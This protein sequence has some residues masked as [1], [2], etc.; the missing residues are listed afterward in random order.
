MKKAYLII[1][2]EFDDRQECIV[3]Y[4]D[5][6]LIEDLF[7]LLFNS[8]RF[9]DPKKYFMYENVTSECNECKLKG[10]ICDKHKL[11]SSLAYYGLIYGYSYHTLEYYFAYNP[12][13]T[14]LY[15]MFRFGS[16]KDGTAYVIGKYNVVNPLSSY[17][18]IDSGTMNIP[19][20]NGRIK[21][22][23]PLVYKKHISEYEYFVF[24]VVS[25]YITWRAYPFVHVNC[26]LPR[27]TLDRI[28]MFLSSEVNEQTNIMEYANRF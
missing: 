6:K 25:D 15:F 13:F 20:I 2:N 10:D 27:E 16:M 21:V 5:N 23:F 17:I 14:L 11:L 7:N 18:T 4:P 19:S 1:T 9:K 24:R 26:P 8:V 28:H 12:E 3:Y 22:T